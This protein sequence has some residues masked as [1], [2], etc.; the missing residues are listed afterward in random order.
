MIVLIAVEMTIIAIMI[1]NVARIVAM[2]G[3]VS[4]EMTIIL[5]INEGMIGIVEIKEEAT[6]TIGGMPMTEETVTQTVTTGSAQEMTATGNLTV[7]NEE[8]D[9]NSSPRRIEGC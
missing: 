5:K 4:K 9:F 6:R 7:T 1:T 3:I 2:D 8:T